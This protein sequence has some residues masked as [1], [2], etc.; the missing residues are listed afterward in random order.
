MQSSQPCCG[1]ECAH[2][3]VRCRCAASARV[4]F[5]FFSLFDLAAN[6][7]VGGLPRNGYGVRRDASHHYRIPCA[8]RAR[9]P[10]RNI[11]PALRS[12]SNTFRESEHVRIADTRAA[13]ALVTMLGRG[14]S[15]RRRL[16]SIRAPAR[17]H[18][19]LQ[20][21]CCCATRGEPSCHDGRN[22]GTRPVA[23]HHLIATPR[24]A[25]SQ[26]DSTLQAFVAVSAT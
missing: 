5:Q 25:G 14:L 26:R 23:L 18:T 19:A 13:H 11:S 16:C 4:R 21:D 22:V 15:H 10:A 12:G 6:L 7:R 20:T 2:G 3:D 17:P 9:N 8:G 24:S 1:V